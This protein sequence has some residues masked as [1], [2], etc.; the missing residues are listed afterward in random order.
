VPTENLCEAMARIRAEWGPVVQDVIAASQGDALI[1][2]RLS[3]FLSA[4][5]RKPDWRVLVGVLRRIIAGERDPLQLLPGLDDTDVVIAGDVLR[6]L[7]VAVPV[8]GLDEEDDDGDVVRL[9]DFLELVAYASRPDAPAELREQLVRATR[10]M[11]TQPNAPAGLRELGR[12]LHSILAGERQPDLSVLPP[13]LEAR[14][15]QM[16]EGLD[17]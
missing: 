8:A 1:A 6:G 9:D 11:A 16:L 7:G 10:G 15:R 3:P 5:E 12:I 4:M 14:V 17:V 13:E 2:A